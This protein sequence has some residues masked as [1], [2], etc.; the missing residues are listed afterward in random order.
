MTKANITIEI[1]EVETDELPDDAISNLDELVYRRI[2]EEYG[3]ELDDVTVT[4][5]E[6]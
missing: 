6:Q 2:A 5:S 4:L 1:Q 3:A